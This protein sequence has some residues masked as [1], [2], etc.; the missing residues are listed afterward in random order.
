MNQIIV[1]VIAT[2][3]GSGIL[4]V[5]TVVGMRQAETMAD[6][7]RLLLLQMSPLLAY[8]TTLWVANHLTKILET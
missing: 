4:A 1:L 2:L 3:S 6:H 5:A 7:M 8:A